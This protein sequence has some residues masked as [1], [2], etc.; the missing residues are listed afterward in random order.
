M[1]WITSENLATAERAA[2]QFIA[3]RLTLA[4]EERGRATLALSGGST[5]WAMIGQLAAQPVTWSAVHVFQVDERIAPAGDAGRNWLRFAASALAARVP[6]NQQHPMPV[7]LDDGEL[8]ADRYSE[9]L[10]RW[11]GDPPAL[12]VVHLGIGPDGHTASLF[13]GDP[14]LEERQRLV[15]VAGEHAG[16]RR[17]SLTLTAIDGA[18]DIVW[19]IVGRDRREVAS[20]LLERDPSIAASRVQREHATC[21]T[22]PEAAPPGHLSGSA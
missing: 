9:T 3:A 19:Y 4:I 21:F 5:P 16:Y 6:R 18:R 2:A 13:A 12:D 11:A 15:G 20:R 8:A 1:E 14:L 10:V 22:D 17:L 7:E